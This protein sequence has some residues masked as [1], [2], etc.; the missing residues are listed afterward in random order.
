VTI[1]TATPG[2]RHLTKR[3]VLA[4][5]QC[6][7]QLWWRV[8]EPDAPELRPSSH[9]RT[10]METGRQVGIL[11][12]DYVPG[13]QL[14]SFRHQTI[15]VRVDATAAAMAGGATALYQ[16]T[17]ARDGIVVQADILERHPS[18]WTLVEVTS[19]VEVKGRQI[20]DAAV[21][22]RV[23]RRSG[24]PLRRIEI[25]HLNRE[26]SSPDLTSLFVREDVTQ[27][28]AELEA[29]IEAEL[30]GQLAVLEGPLPYRE[31]GDHCSHP[32]RCPF[33]DR[34]WPELA[35]QHVS[36]VYRA[37]LKAQEWV[38]Q[39]WQTILDLPDDLPL[40]PV[41]ARQV[42]AVKSGRIQVDSGLAT[43]LEALV[44]PLAFL[45]FEAVGP[46]VPRWPGC[47]PYE[48][49]PV[50]LS[51]HLED[52]PGQYR[53]LEW[54]ADGPDD[55]RPGFAQFVIECCAGA[56]HIVTYNAAYEADCLRHLARVLPR[57]SSEL[58]DIER[59]LVDL[60]PVVRDY[61]Y[62]PEFEG[63]FSLKHVL[64]ALVPELRYAGMDISEGRT[65][66]SELAG[67]LFSGATDPQER[68]MV[69]EALLAYCKQD[70]WGM[71]CLLRRL[72]ELAINN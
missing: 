52:G 27:R 14:I 30:R 63:S 21:Q 59:R 29:G 8:H 48:A 25:M 1:S 64:P 5:L 43:A 18:G 65:A 4:G 11:A 20:V 71:V 53:H 22:A 41:A 50:Q 16:G 32:D 54:L 39:G 40:G 61:V 51:C 9:S 56:R 10:A 37:G 46:A 23:L 19:T 42:A 35:P 31:T 66:S 58:A 49:V 26:C 57:W 68:S 67:L 38:A 17:F 62:H 34:C 70:T 2:P 47:G 44:Q 55:P 24:V 33:W 15:P 28:V 69:R 3:E 6:H 13:G 45:D 72:R 60:L 12:R 36:T 7:K